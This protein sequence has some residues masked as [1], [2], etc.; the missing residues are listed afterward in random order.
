LRVEHRQSDDPEYLA[1]NPQRRCPNLEKSRRLLAYE[2]RV[3]LSTGLERL[4]QYYLANPV[5]EDK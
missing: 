1:D 3:P 5:A 4:Y 2:P